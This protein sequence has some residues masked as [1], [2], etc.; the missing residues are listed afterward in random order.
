M[1]QEAAKIGRIAQQPIDDFA[2]F[3]NGRKTVLSHNGERY[4]SFFARNGN[5]RDEG[6]Y[7]GDDCVVLRFGVA[8]HRFDR[9]VYFALV[10]FPHAGGGICI[11]QLRVNGVIHVDGDA[12]I[13]IVAGCPCD[14]IAIH[15]LVERAVVVDDEVRGQTARA[16][17][18]ERIERR[19][20][21]IVMERDLDDMLSE[22]VEFGARRAEKLFGAAVKLT[23]VTHA[24]ILHCGAQKRHL[25]EFVGRERI[26]GVIE[27]RR[28]VVVEPQDGIICLNGNFSSAKEYVFFHNILPWMMRA[29]CALC[30]LRNR[31]TPSNGLS[32]GVRNRGKS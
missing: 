3:G 14:V 5:R 4:P 17:D 28:G 22:G 2:G 6:F 32:W 7:Q 10:Y 12:V 23:A 30:L 21:D 20:G 15:E 8:E 29:N 24:V 19:R 9:S 27:A 25:H 1:A 11:A 18:I 31:G 26:F 13:V 16:Q